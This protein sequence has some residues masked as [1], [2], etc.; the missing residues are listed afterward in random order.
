[1]PISAQDL[2]RYPPDW[3]EISAAIKWVRAGGRC[4]CT[5]E[6][7]RPANHLGPDQRC[8][9]H[10][11]RSAWHTG[12]LVILSAA[13]LDHQPEN[14][15]P[16]KPAGPMPRAATCITTGPTTRPADEL[17]GWPCWAWARCSNRR[18]CMAHPRG[19]HVPVPY[20]ASTRASSRA[21][22]CSPASAA[23][24]WW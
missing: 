10:Q 5:G 7:G 4:E 9:N 2:L 14:H 8:R 3:D 18:R 19:Y 12:S 17:G 1:M 6:C 11:G 22:S 16:D 24:W 20:R 23:M 15:D 13:H 21:H